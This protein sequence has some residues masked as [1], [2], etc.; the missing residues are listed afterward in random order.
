MTSEIRLKRIQ[1]FIGRMPSLSTVAKVL[2]ICNNP[3]ASA[4]DL[5]R[6]IS[7]D[8]V[9]TAQVLKL[10]NSAYYG[11][12]NR[13]TSLVRAIIMRQYGQEFGVGQFGN[14]GLQRGL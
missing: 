3:G 11:L 14:G 1:Q 10:I 5:N 13:I 7:Y 2:D 8:P 9:L 6:V 4:N 12:P